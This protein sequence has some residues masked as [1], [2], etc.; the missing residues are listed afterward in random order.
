MTLLKEEDIVK[1]I[2]FLCLRRHG[3]VGRMKNRVPE[4]DN[5]CNERIKERRKTT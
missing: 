3:Q 5:S 4:N 2:K 1:F